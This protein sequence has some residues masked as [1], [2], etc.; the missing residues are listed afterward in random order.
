MLDVGCGSDFYLLSGVKHRI[1][2]GVGMD[3]AVTNRKTGNIEIRKTEVFDKLPF[4][5]GSF[6]VVTMIAFIEHIDKPEKIARECNRVLR[7]GGRLIIT[8]PMGQAKPFW[9]LL[10]N[11]GLT[12]EKTTEDHKQYFNPQKIEKLLRDSGFKIEVS[13]KFEMGMNYVAVGKKI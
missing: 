8:T 3:V 6:D 10:V 12:E 2:R 9:E 1:K 11:L 13:R 7:K 5:A 4:A